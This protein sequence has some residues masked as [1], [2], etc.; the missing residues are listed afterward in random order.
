M[1]EA[2]TAQERVVGEELVPVVGRAGGEV[3]LDE[4]VERELRRV[5][6]KLERQVW[7]DLGECLELEVDDR[8]SVGDGDFVE[9][10]RV[11]ALA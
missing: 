7:L 8:L 4:Q 1:G 11:A 2:P 9:R 3:E 5:D 10:E 6:A